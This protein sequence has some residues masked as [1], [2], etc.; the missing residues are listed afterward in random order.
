MATETQGVAPEIQ[1]R[2]SFCAK[3]GSEVEKVIAGPGVYIC[4]ECVGLCNDI[5]GAERAQVGPS[6]AKS[7]AELAAWERV[8]DRRADPR[9]APA[10]RRGRGSDRGEPAAAGRHF[11]RAQGDLGSHRHRPADHPAVSM[12]TVLRRGVT[13]PPDGTLFRCRP[14]ILP[15]RLRGSFPEFGSRVLSRRLGSARHRARIIWPCGTHA[16]FYWPCVTPAG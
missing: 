15:V 11:A 9:P 7:A 6:W 2:C 12:G 10:H 4:S 1:V 13:Q 5:L 14:D 3:P 8:D 16:R